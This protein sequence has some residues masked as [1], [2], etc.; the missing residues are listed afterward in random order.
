MRG[1]A[2]LSVGADGR[3][4]KGAFHLVVIMSGGTHVT[5]ISGGQSRTPAVDRCWLIAAACM[6]PAAHGQTT[7]QGDVAGIYTNIKPN[8]TG[9]PQPAIPLLVAGPRDRDCEARHA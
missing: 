3:A 8:C 1:H 6:C 5:R 4:G 2:P 9:G 7:G